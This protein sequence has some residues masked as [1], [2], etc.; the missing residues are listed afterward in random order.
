M[1]IYI[2]RRVAFGS[3]LFHQGSSSVPQL[4]IIASG[5]LELAHSPNLAGAA[6]LPLSHTSAADNNP[7]RHDLLSVYNH[8]KKMHQPPAEAAA[9]NN[10]DS[11]NS[12][13]DNNNN[14][15]GGGGGKNNF[16]NNSSS[17][18]SSSSVVSKRRKNKAEG[19][20]S[21][22]SRRLNPNKGSN[23]GKEESA[24]STGVLAGASEHGGIGEL[25][26]TVK[27][28]DLNRDETLKLIRTRKG[29]SR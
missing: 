15:G 13:D 2:Y 18:S 23:K 9:S 12:P 7:P 19:A 3:D 17:S 1:Y 6:L 28:T 16:K 8:L 24:E 11:P 26:E 14:N 5:Q 27:L 22:N 21:S 10:P 4:T 25:N 29:I 20:K